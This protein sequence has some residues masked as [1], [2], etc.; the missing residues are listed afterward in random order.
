MKTMLL[1]S[2]TVAVLATF[3]TAFLLLGC[4]T[5]S[6]IQRY[7][8][9][10]S[11]FTKAPELLTNNF[12]ADDIYCIYHRG[13][14][15]FTS[16]ESLRDEVT[17]RAETFAKQQDKSMVVLGERTSQPPYIFGNFPRIELV[18]AL[19]DKSTSTFPLPPDKYSQLE[20][21]KTLLDKGVLTKE[22]FEQEKA[23]V[24][25]QTPEP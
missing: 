21:L 14:T 20:K 16:I 13:S 18:F 15:G 9:S 11:H 17:K 4:A 8:Q 1:G 5:S 2:R 12:P 25:K 22:E 10:R 23:K 19:T 6:P 3:T 24:L 7:D